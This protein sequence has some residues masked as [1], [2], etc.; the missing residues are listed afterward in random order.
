MAMNVVWQDVR[1]ALRMLAKSP[2]FTLVAL[3]TLA[4][5]VGANTAIFT[6]VDSVLLRPLPYPQ[7]SQLVRISDVQPPHEVVSSADYA[8]FADWREQKQVFSEVAASFQSQFDMSGRGDP[9]RVNGIRVSANFLPMLGIEPMVGRGFTPEEETRSGERVCLIS[10]ELWKRKFGGSSGVLGQTLK[11]SEYPYTVIGVLSAKSDVPFAPDIVAGMRLDSSVAPRGFHFLQVIARLRPGISL[12]QARQEIELFAASLRTARSID[13]GIALESLREVTT[14]GAGTP[15]FVMLGAVGFVLLIACA[16]VANLL[17]ARAQERRRE[18]AIRAAL[19]ATRL[20]IVRQLLTESG[21]LAIAGAALGLLAASWVTSFLLSANLQQ[22]PRSREIHMDALVYLFAAFL[23]V[24]TMLFFGLSPALIILRSSSAEVLK[25]GIR[26][27]GK[28]GRQ[29]NILIV[30]EIALSLVLLIGTGLLLRS[31][32]QLLKV[33]KGFDSQK[34]LTFDLLL[35][36]THYPKTE[37]QVAFAREVSENLKAVPGVE[38]VGTINQLVLGPDNVNGDVVIEGKTYPK[39]AGPIADK[40]ITGGDYFSALHIP[41]LRGRYFDQRD[42]AGATQVAVINEAFARK[43][44]PGEDA[45]GKRVDF[46]WDTTGWQEIVG[47]IGNVKHDALNLPS[48][49]EVYVPFAQR[50]DPAFTVTVR[51][52]ANPKAMVGAVREQIAKADASLPLAHLQTMD[53][54]VSASIGNQRFTLL[55]LGTFALLALGL[56]VIGLYGVIAYTV[57]LRTREIGIRLALGAGRSDVLRMVLG[58]AL[59]FVALGSAA[60]LLAAFALTRFMSTL[61]FN[62]RPSDVL[63]YA[64]ITTILAFVTLAASYM[65]ARRATSVDPLVALRYE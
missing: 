56:T 50:P 47:V 24:L 59:Q 48:N 43:Y 32:D 29:R 63:T 23:A 16:N 40:R 52:Y 13:H 1:Y 15:L 27:S 4:I 45:I 54:V 42:V 21:L 7:S 41:L 38:F 18:I 49:P 65:P 26:G 2:G 61:L 51:T 57:S 30:S 37:Q 33:D 20:R 53:E 11:L 64:A 46:G 31:F 58:E 8:E 55:L 36:P 35:P 9:E 25:N 28:S 14:R 44:F 10:E 22:I 62:V 60:G 19:G 3:L 12:Q 5:G 6:V 39:G 17:L 34:V